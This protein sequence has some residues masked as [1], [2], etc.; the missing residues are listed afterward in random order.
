MYHHWNGDCNRWRAIKVTTKSYLV[1][2]ARH[3]AVMIPDS[4]WGGTSNRAPAAV[5]SEHCS[6]IQGQSLREAA[7]QKPTSLQAMWLGRAWETRMQ[8]GDV[9]IS[10]LPSG[11]SLRKQMNTSVVGCRTCQSM[12][13]FMWCHSSKHQ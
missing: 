11:A 2:P 8:R 12:C 10:S 3:A 13:K 7:L 6:H 1:S 9:R 5:S 4:M